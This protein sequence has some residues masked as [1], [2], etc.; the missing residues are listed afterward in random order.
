MSRAARHSNLTV[1]LCVNARGLGVRVNAVHYK[2]M[3]AKILSAPAAEA[4][5]QRKGQ[6]FHQMTKVPPRV[7][8]VGL[9]PTLRGQCNWEVEHVRTWTRCGSKAF[10]VRATNPPPLHVSVIDHHRV[11]VQLAPD[12]PR[13]QVQIL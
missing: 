1:G 2:D 9:R 8:F 5:Q 7:D 6:H 4:L 13:P 11:P 12:Q 3:V 10:T